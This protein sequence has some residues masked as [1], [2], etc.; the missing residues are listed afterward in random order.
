M[1][2]M[3]VSALCFGLLCVALLLVSCQAAP[4]AAPTPTAAPPPPTAAPDLVAPVEAWVDAI[5]KGDVDAALE[6]LA[7]NALWS[8][9]YMLPGEVWKSGGKEK[10]R[11]DFNYLVGMEVKSGIKDCQPQDDR[12]VCG[13]SMVDG[14]MVAFGAPD[15]LAAKLVF[16][17]QPD[18][19]VREVSF[20]LDDPRLED[21]TKFGIAS[22]AWAVENR[23]EEHVKINPRQSWLGG[24][25]DA[26]FCKEYAASLKAAPPT[27]VPPAPAADLVAP[28]KVFVA[29]MNAGDVNATLALFSDDV[30]WS[31]WM[32]PAFG[33][34][35]SRAVL[36]YLV[37]REAK[38][39][40]TDCQPQADR[41]VCD[42]SY[43]D[44]CSAASGY[45]G[46][47]AEAAKLVF[48]YQPDGKVKQAIFSH[49]APVPEDV[50]K[51]W[52]DFS[53]WVHA[54]RSED[55]AKVGVYDGEGGKLLVELCQEYAASLK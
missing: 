37:A 49:G 16:I 26:K 1:R 24:S 28:V 19:K 50:T 42:L 21:Y 17:Y 23:A 18:G 47:Q 54:N 43:V 15:G 40:I 14:C 9:R 48:I 2:Y 30:R 35:P 38:S 53:A 3:K 13:L 22:D 45:P 8:A 52:A 39:Q 11:R 51:F 29:A 32:V 6:L 46:D 34:E 55:V 36:E 41:V 7:D 25:L 33:K 5:N 10:V 12:V 31:A 44:G 20:I 4:M 27:P